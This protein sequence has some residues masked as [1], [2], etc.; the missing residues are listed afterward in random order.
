MQIPKNTVH[1]LICN[2]IFCVSKARGICV[3]VGVCLRA[4]YVCVRERARERGKKRERKSACVRVYVCVCVCICV[5]VCVC[6]CVYVCVCVCVF[7][8]MFVCVCMCVCVRACER[9]R[10]H[11]CV[12]AVVGVLQISFRKRASNGQARLKEETCNTLQ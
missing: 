8:C 9:E 6:V 7:V 2:C 1:S 3:R 5:C 11:V 4:V 12:Y 10:V